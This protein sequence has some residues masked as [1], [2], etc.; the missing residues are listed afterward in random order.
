MQISKTYLVLVQLFGKEPNELPFLRTV[1]CTKFCFAEFERLSISKEKILRD[2]HIQRFNPCIV[3]P[4]SICPYS[5]MLPKLKAWESAKPASYFE[6]RKMESLFAWSTL[7]GFPFPWKPLSQ[8][9]TPPYYTYRH[10]EIP[11]MY[12]L[13]AFQMPTFSDTCKTEGLSQKS[14]LC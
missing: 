8:K 2:S 6:D 1:K 5:V 11:S 3:C 4:P 14:Q 7:Q 10:I 12:S 13:S 9:E